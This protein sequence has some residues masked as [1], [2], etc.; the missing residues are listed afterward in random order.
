MRKRWQATRDLNRP[1]EGH[2]RMALPPKQMISSKLRHALHSANASHA[3]NRKTTKLPLS[4]LS[5]S[6]KM[7]EKMSEKISKLKPQNTAILFPGQG[8][9]TVGMGLDFV[10]AFPIAKETLDLANN[11]LRDNIVDA[12]DLIQLIGN[13]PKQTLTLTE[14]AQ[15][16]ILAVSIAI[17]RVLEKEFGFNIRNAGFAMGHSLGEYSA[18]VA[19]NVLSLD[20]AILL[21]RKRGQSMTDCLHSLHKHTSMLAMVINYD[22]RDEIDEITVAGTKVKR[23][24]LEAIQQRLRAINDCVQ[25]TIQP[26]LMEGEVAEI[27]NSNSSRQIVLSGTTFGLDMAAQVLSTEQLAHPA[28]ELPVSA[29]FHSSLLKESRKVMGGVLE[30]THFDT[31]TIP[32]IS[33]VTAQPISDASLLPHL[34]A[35]QI[36][37]T[38]C[39]YNSMLFLKDQGVDTWLCLGPGKAVANLV[40]KEFPADE[41]LSVSSVR[42]LS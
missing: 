9:Q 36:T 4:P 13:G 37:S 20:A 18:L 42:D 2:R 19:A 21:V 35:E 25:N 31:P 24:R 3:V 8:S 41:V 7:S 33:N 30:N 23:Y 29:P 5:Q 12:P 28:V 27:S 22:K 34:L 17:L 14:N 32:I 16:A 10:K 26:M 11:T 1:D 40:R 6:Q 38:V 15:P 39:F